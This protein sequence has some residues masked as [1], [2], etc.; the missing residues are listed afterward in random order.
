MALIQKAI[1]SLYLG[2]SQQEESNRLEGQVSESINMIHSVEKGVGRR[3]PTEFIANISGVSPDTFIHSYARGDDIEEYIIVVDGTVGD[4]KVYT[5]GGTPI[6]V[7]MNAGVSNYLTIPTGKSATSFKALT[8]GDSTFILNNQIICSMSPT[9]DGVAGS[10]YNNP[11]YWVKRSFDN[12][13]GTGYDY[14][15]QGVTVNGTKTTTVASSLASSLGA[16]YVNYGS[17]VVSTVKPASWV[18]SDSYGAQA[19]E[20]FWGV[21]QKI[22]D[23]PNTLSGAENVYEFLV[24]I[25]GDPDNSYTNYWVKYDNG[26]WKETRAPGLQNT[27]A[28]TTMP[29]KLVRQSDGTFLASLIDYNPR[30]VGDEKTASV[31]SFIGRSITDIFFFKNRLCFTAG[32]NVIMSEIGEYFNFFPTTVTDVLDSDPIDGAVDSN[33]VALLNH[34]IPFDNTVI[35]LSNDA[36]FSLK[37]D[38]V[39]S[40]NDVSISSTTDYNAL[41]NVQPVALGSSMYFLSESLKGTALREYYVSGDSNTKLAVDVSGHASEYLPLNI[42]NM[43][44]SSNQD[45]LFI[46]ST[47]TPN[48]IYVYKFYNDGQERIQTAWFKW[49]LSGYIYNITLLGE[50]LYL[51]IDRGS[52]AQLERID[53]SSNSKV[54]TF[55]DNGNINYISSVKLSRLVLKDGNNRVIQSA[56]APLMYRTF[57]LTSTDNSVYKVLVGHTIRDRVVEK[58][59]LKDHKFLVQ[60]KSK[61]L[62][63][64]IQSVDDNPLEFHTYTIEA[65]YNIRAKVI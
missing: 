12:G 37:S 2:V 36:Q 48:T 20:G 65:N 7:N 49:E 4:I 16:N 64:T 29:I 3:N 34:A 30:E 60:G 42:I 32:E 24:E 14:S 27:I 63:L 53:Y 47:D 31:P 35:L 38:A 57:R 9:V 8:V 59:A 54:T 26:H 62:T 51:L 45:V 28:N 61:D 11:W 1:N 58:F 13:S 25:Q 6:T 10:N 39:L 33:S 44:G 52:G 17:I 5:T 18:W 56:R 41:K 46:L 19:S 21:A 50:Y 43:V 40:P 55:K 23:L 22:G 15:L